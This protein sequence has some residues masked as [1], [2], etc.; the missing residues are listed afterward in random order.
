MPIIKIEVSHDQLDWLT[1]NT[2]NINNFMCRLLND[3]IYRTSVRECTGLYKLIKPFEL[4]EQAT[5]PAIL[6]LAREY[7]D[8]CHQ[9]SE[10]AKPTHKYS[11]G[12]ADIFG[13][14]VPGS[15]RSSDGALPLMFSSGLRLSAITFNTGIDRNKGTRW[16]GF[17]IRMR[18]PMRHTVIMR[19][20]DTATEEE[21]DTLAEIFGR[22]RNPET[23]AYKKETD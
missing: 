12:G 2:L 22:Y 1:A 5:T 3:E 23:G 15:I 18:D 20:F 8:T 4:G 6:E 14:S 13:V 21:G 7:V 11:P 10:L 19:Q 16:I 17:N 9:L